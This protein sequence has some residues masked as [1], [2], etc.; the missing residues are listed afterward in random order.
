MNTVP[1]IV[2]F[3][4]ECSLLKVDELSNRLTFDFVLYFVWTPPTAGIKP[5]SSEEGG[6]AFVQTKQKP[7]WFPVVSF[8][9]LEDKSVMEETFFANA[10][11]SY[12]CL[13]NWVLRVNETLELERFP[14]DRQMC[15][16]MLDIPSVR[17]VPIP[18]QFVVPSNFPRDQMRCIADIGN[19]ILDD[20]NVILNVVGG[21]E[22]ELCDSDVTIDMHLTRD[23]TY[24]LWN[25][26]VV[27]F[28]LVLAAFSVVG[29]PH[30]ELAD[31]MSITMTLLLTIV[32]FKFVMQSYV[33]P[34]P[35]LT[36]LDKYVLASFLIVGVV[37]LEN[38]LVSFG[39][40]E[41][42]AS[43]DAAFAA[44]LAILWVCFHVF[45]VIGTRFMWFHLDWKD[46]LENDESSMHECIKDSTRVK[47]KDDTLSSLRNS[48]DTSSARRRRSK[49]NVEIATGKA[50]GETSGTNM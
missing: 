41:T 46:V 14:Y 26:V 6:E 24:Y 45:I 11:G 21:S 15:K 47:I 44:V 39:H 16:V 18:E 32:A 19:W 31:R 28:M 9:N 20:A 43:G 50:K 27:V 1:D 42:V 3:S 22:G 34:T 4:V 12:A 13:I 2:H 17:A 30:N 25:I 5:S 7:P 38:F 23:P 37:I 48:R 49:G 36:L 29:V 33:P 35:Y 8:Y 10:N 40:E